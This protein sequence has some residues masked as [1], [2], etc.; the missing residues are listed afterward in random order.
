MSKMLKSNRDFAVQMIG[1]TVNPVYNVSSN[2]P[3]D[4][5]GIGFNFTP[6]TFYLYFI[7]MDNNK[8]RVRHYFYPN[9]DDTINTS[10]VTHF[11]PLSLDD[12]KNKAQDIINDALNANPL[13]THLMDD[14]NFLNVQ[15]R[16][17]SYICLVVD[18]PGWKFA[19]EDDPNNQHPVLMM[20]PHGKYSGNTAFFDGNPM[21]F[22]DP[23]L[24]AVPPAGDTLQGFYVV[25]HMTKNLNG[26]LLS[27]NQVQKFG[28][29]ICFSV[30]YFDPQGTEQMICIFDPGGENLGPPVGPP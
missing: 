22:S 29:N 4:G 2:H 16:K 27:P 9:G 15:W 12:L 14:R 18:I 5:T 25:N 19:T 20:D 21:E 17:I 1:A 10:D 30:P 13:N 11:P 8:P 3:T 28:F 26:D 6:R 7:D 24:P 23:R